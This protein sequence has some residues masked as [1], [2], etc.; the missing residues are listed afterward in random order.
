MAATQGGVEM[1]LRRSFRHLCDTLRGGGGRDHS[2]YLITQGDPPRA[3]VGPIGR[4]DMVKEW[5]TRHK[6]S[7]KKQI[8][9]GCLFATT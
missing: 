6:N 1:N 3:E 9:N 4:A 8:L 5:N 7:G 2:Q